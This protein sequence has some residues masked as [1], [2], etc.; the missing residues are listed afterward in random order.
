MLTQPAQNHLSLL[1]EELKKGAEALMRSK[2]Y[3]SVLLF[4]LCACEYLSL[5]YAGSRRGTANRGKKAFHQFL[6]RYF[7]RFNRDCRD[8][9]G[10]VRRVRIT[11]A[12]G[13]GKAA[14]R[15][16]LHAALIYLFRRGTVEDL[17]ADQQAE[18]RCVTL[19]SGRWG[20]RINVHEFFLDFI[21]SVD[22][23]RKDVMNDPRLAEN[24]LQRF[25]HLYG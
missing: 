1:S 6:S 18:G 25:N 16:R 14:R 11:V 5:Y 24:F 8:Q 20:F 7:P 3:L 12:K 17:L 2:S 15:M 23:Y 10:H 4:I 13:G 9:E 21:E 22:E 19:C